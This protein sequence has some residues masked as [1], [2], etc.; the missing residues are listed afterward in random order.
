MYGAGGG[1]NLAWDTSPPRRDES[2]TYAFFRSI[3]WTRMGYAESHLHHDRQDHRA[4]VRFFV[5]KLAQCVLDFVLDKGPV[6]SVA[7]QANE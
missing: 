4:A 7:V 2:R 1:D 5:E 6:G 3:I